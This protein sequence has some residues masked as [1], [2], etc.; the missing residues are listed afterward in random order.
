M[1]KQGDLVLATKYSDGDPQDH[2]C[3]GY[4]RDMT[5]HDEPRYN[6]VNEDGELFRGNGFRKCRK[7]EK[8]HAQE[9]INKFEIIER[10]GIS[11]WKWLRLI[12]KN[13]HHGASQPV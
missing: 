7:I 2:F 6:V 5:T 4:F 11:V 1:L 13:Q 8:A 3:V 12:K 10:S 9:I